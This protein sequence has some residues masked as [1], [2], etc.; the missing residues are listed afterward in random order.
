M[1]IEFK[2]LHP[3]A[4]VPTPGSLWSAGYDLTAATLRKAGDVYIFGTGLAVEIP[5]GWFGAMYARSSIYL[6]PLHKAGGVT[7]VDSDYR[8]ELMVMFRHVQRTDYN[9]E[10]LREYLQLLGQ[11]DKFPLM[12][13]YGVGD[14]IAQIVFQPCAAVDF[15]EVDDLSPTARGAGGYGSTGR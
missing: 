8:G 1:E 6:Q 9:C 2:R 4:V 5:K 11:E 7:V 10:R 12:H 14:R 13:P 15:V 3:N